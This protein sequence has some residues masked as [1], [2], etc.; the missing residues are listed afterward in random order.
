MHDARSFLD[1]TISQRCA[2]KSMVTMRLQYLIMFTLNVR[3]I[4]D[5]CAY[6]FTLAGMRS[7]SNYLAKS[8]YQQAEF[9]KIG[10][11]RICDA[12]A[13][14]DIPN[15]TCRTFHVHIDILP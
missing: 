6:M 1:L 14:E 12:I 13:L 4:R 8:V 7:A 15:A 3:I 9:D 2:V 5:Q 11:A 10:V